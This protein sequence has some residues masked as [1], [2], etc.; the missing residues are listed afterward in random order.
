MSKLKKGFIAFVILTWISKLS[1]S[2]ESEKLA[3]LNSN[4]DHGYWLEENIDKKFN[5]EWVGKFHT[6]HRWGSNYSQ[7]YHQ[8][9][10]LNFQ[11]NLKEIFRCLPRNL[12]ESFTIGPAYNLTR[13]LQ[14]NTEEIYHWVWIKRSV[15]EMRLSSSIWGWSIKQRI[16][17]E[18]YDYTKKHYEDHGLLRYRLEFYTPWKFGSYKINPYLSNEWFFRRNSYHSTTNPNG[19]VGGWYENRFRIGL[20]LDLFKHLSNSIYWQWLIRKQKPGT[21]PRWFNNYQFG[22]VTNL[23]F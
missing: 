15:A 18:Y 13:A 19:L 7:L 3:K 4:N 2:A 6:E 1:L 22:L 20:A 14:K 21:N 10:E 23:S 8:E 17:G 16:R 12:I 11:Y 5:K 9:Y